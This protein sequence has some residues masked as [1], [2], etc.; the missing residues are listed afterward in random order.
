MVGFIVQSTVRNSASFWTAVPMRR[1]RFCPPWSKRQRTGALPDAAA[2]DCAGARRSRRFNV[3]TADAPD[4]SRD[5]AGRTVKRAEARAPGRA[6]QGH[7]IPALKRRAIFRLSR[8]D[9]CKCVCANF[10]LVS[11]TMGGTGDPPVPVGDPPTGMA[12]A[13]R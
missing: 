2:T 3:R 7:P 10:I 6:T 11:I 13:V 1:D 5:P 8:R 4:F 12:E 9:D